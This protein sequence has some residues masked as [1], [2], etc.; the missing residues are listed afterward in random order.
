MAEESGLIGID[1]GGTKIEA[2]LLN[3]GHEVVWRRRVPTPADDYQATL[4]AIRGLIES[5]EQETG[6]SGPVGMATP[7]SI[8]RVS[9]RMKNCNSICL[10]GQPLREDLQRLLDRPVRIANDADCL[11]LS[12]TVDGSAAG[13]QS[14]FAAILG[15][16]VGA[17]IT[18]GGKILSGPNGIAGEWGHNPLAEHLRRG[19]SNRDCYCG[20]LNCVET[21]LSGPGLELSWLQRTGEQ[22]RGPGIVARAQSG[23]PDARAVMDMYFDRLAGALAMVVNI[24]DPEFIVFGGGLSALP[25]LCDEVQKRWSRD[26]FSDSVDTR[27]AVARHGD[28]SGVRGAA[29]LWSGEA[30]S[31]SVPK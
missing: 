22:L 18:I 6:C 24:L 3:A 17:G 2:A 19:E 8:S 11:A 7:G 25:S 16:G 12:E 30:A 15:T 9:C 5:L 28:S 27:L 1:L 29:W 14:V 21:F 4:S 13:A 31:L 23:D 26:I 20:R 10:N